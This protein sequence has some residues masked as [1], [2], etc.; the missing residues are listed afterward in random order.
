MRRVLADLLP[1]FNVIIFDAA[2]PMI[3]WLERSL[4]HT[5]LIS[6]DH[7]L[8][9]HD[10]T[11]PGDGRLVANYLATFQCVCPVI[12]HTSNLQAAP[13]MMSVLRGARWFCAFVQP[14]DGF[15]WISKEWRDEIEETYRRGWIFE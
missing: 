5:V 13:G 1:A 14:Q 9:T 12:V 6:L 4:S 8:V 11:E 3:R 15:G 7:D 10:G 2:G